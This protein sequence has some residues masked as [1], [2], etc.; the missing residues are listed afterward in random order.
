MEHLAC[1]WFSSLFGRLKMKLEQNLRLKLLRKLEVASSSSSRVCE[2][3][4]P[5]E[6]SAT[7]SEESF[8]RNTQ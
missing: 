8:L 3:I 1:V 6:K 2:V 4:Y 5:L 7:L